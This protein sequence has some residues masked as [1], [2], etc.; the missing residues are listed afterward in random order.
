[1]SSS[2][3]SI[4]RRSSGGPDPA[5]GVVAI[6]VA[7][8]DVYNGTPSTMTFGGASGSTI[9]IPTLTKMRCQCFDGANY[10]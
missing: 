1:M 7:A 3:Y 8:Y 6:N 5:R 9:S 10:V 4:N 2:N